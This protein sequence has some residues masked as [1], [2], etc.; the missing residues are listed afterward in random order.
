M[1]GDSAYESV[2][3]EDD[4]LSELY[5]KWSAY[6]IFEAIISRSEGKITEVVIEAAYTCDKLRM[7]EFGGSIHRITADSVQEGGTNQ[8]LYWFRKNPGKNIE[9]F[10]NK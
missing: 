4:K 9:D 3:G 10:G 5:S 1:D 7:G 2:E 8:L 6:S